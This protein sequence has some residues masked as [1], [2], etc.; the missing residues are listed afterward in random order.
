[1]SVPMTVIMTQ[2]FKRTDEVKLEECP[3]GDK[4]CFLCEYKFPYK[5][6][7]AYRSWTGEPVCI[8]IEKNNDK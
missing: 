7:K 1:M 6:H 2:K 4:N 5:V 8:A 3:K